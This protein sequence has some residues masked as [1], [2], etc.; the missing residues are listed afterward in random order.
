MTSNSLTYS[1]I[2]YAWG[3]GTLASPSSQNILGLSFRF[4]EARQFNS[5]IARSCV[6]RG[7][8][9]PRIETKGIRCHPT[10]LTF[11]DGDEIFNRD[12]KNRGSAHVGSLHEPEKFLLARAIE[13]LRRLQPGGLIQFNEGVIVTPQ[14]RQASGQI[15]V[16]V[17][18]G[19]KSKSL[20]KLGFRGGEILSVE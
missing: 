3:N 20:A 2:D 14:A 12:C 10:P 11:R 13:I 15:D 6:A 4:A 1:L 9:E 17:G 7:E 18:C 19:L 16:V 8:P 5:A